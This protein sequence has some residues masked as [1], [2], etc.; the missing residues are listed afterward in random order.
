M[1]VR[2]MLP[3]HVNKTVLITRLEGS[4]VVVEKDSIKRI[5]FVKVSPVIII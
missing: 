3:I 4:I 2:P 5:F 1:N